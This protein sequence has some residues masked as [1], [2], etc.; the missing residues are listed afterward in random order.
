MNEP[1]SSNEGTDNNA[2]KPVVIQRRPFQIPPADL[3]PGMTWDLPPPRKKKTDGTGELDPA[4]LI[5]S[6]RRLLA[7]LAPEVEVEVRTEEKN[8]VYRLPDVISNG[9]FV[10]FPAI[11]GES[12]VPVNIYNTKTYNSETIRVASGYGHDNSVEGITE[13]NRGEIEQLLQR[14]L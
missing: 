5:D 1:T 14:L 12:Y 10:R 4:G 13:L 6:L 11:G 9:M 3:E 2:F 7:G 8:Y